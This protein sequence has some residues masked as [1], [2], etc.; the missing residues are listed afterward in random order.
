M[1]QKFG[2]ANDGNVPGVRSEGKDGHAANVSIEI[3]QPLI[4]DHPEA[5]TGR[6]PL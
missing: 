3:N 2:F 6:N 4:R 1:S 5:A